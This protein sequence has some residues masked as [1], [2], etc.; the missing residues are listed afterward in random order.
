MKMGSTT[1]DKMDMENENEIFPLA[2]NPDMK[3]Y[4]EGIHRA[5]VC[6]YIF[7]GLCL[8]IAI[9]R[10]LFGNN[11]GNENNSINP[12]FLLGVSGLIYFLLGLWSRQ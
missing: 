9:S 7:A 8:A 10:F 11:P 12:L 5:R 4:S 1:K 3:R 6:I 2:I